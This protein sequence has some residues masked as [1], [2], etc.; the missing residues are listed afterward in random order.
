MS[1]Q[2]VSRMQTKFEKEHVPTSTSRPNS[3]GIR[4]VN[5]FL[6][7]YNTTNLLRLP[8]SV[9]SVPVN[10]VLSNSKSSAPNKE[11]GSV[12]KPLR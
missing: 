4:P 1:K 10:P 11:N 9:G 7:R 8:S 3:D 6:K 5:S 2:T 12:Q